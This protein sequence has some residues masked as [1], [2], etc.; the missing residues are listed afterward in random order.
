VVLF[1]KKLRIIW[2]MAVF[3]SE[4]KDKMYAAV[5]GNKNPAPVNTS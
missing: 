1:Q 4:T 3:F 5:D 2:G